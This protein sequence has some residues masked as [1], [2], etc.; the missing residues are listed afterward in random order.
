M[1]KLIKSLIKKN[2][3]LV[4]LYRKLIFFEN[5]FLK[6]ILNFEKLMLF[7]KVYPYTM[8]NYQ[9]L[10]NIYNLSKLIEGQRRDGVFV[11]CGVCKGGCAAVMAFV[12]HKARSGRKIWLFDSFE[13]LPEPIDK[14]GLSAKSYASNKI[15]GRLLS[16]DKCVGELEDVK[17]IFFSI[18]RIEKENTII[19]KGWF[20]DT[21]AKTKDQVGPIA[22]LHLDGDWYESTKCCLDNLYDNVVRGGYIVIDD[23]YCWEG[24]R[25]AV[26]E[27]LKKRSIRVSLIRISRDK[28]YFKKP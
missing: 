8:I 1:L 3:K 9:G 18:L 5:L 23:Y 26:D 13:G 12:A 21:L 16:I 11:E 25:K 10:S 27:F 24:C 17:R 7:K 22:I 28:V 14:D 2:Q 6:D 19:R 20:Q 15:S 4:D